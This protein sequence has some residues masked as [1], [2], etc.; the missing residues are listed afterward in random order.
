MDHL[1]KFH[2]NQMV[3]EPENA[4]LQKLCKQKK[5]WRLAPKSEKGGV[6]RDYTIAWRFM[7]R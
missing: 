4:V 2:Q 1:S 6:W 5:W 3:N 7:L